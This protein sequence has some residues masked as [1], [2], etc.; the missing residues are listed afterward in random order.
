MYAHHGTING[1]TYYIQ[2]NAV[3]EDAVLDVGTSTRGTDKVVSDQPAGEAMSTLSGQ[4]GCK[5]STAQ[6]TIRVYARR[7]TVQQQIDAQTCPLE[8][9]SEMPHR[10]YDHSCDLVSA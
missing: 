2:Y 9:D 6:N 7:S 8:R 1:S 4:C 3:G 5:V 10:C